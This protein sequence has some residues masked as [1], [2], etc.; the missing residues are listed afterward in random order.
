[1]DALPF[2][3]PALIAKKP[4]ESAYPS[5]LQTIGD[6]IRARRLDLRIFQ[7]D[8]AKRIGVTTDTITN[9][10][11]HRSTPTLRAWPAVLLFLGYDPRPDGR[12]IGE[13]LR[14]RRQALGLS[15]AEA[16]RIIGVDPSTLSKWEFGRRQPVGVHLEKVDRFLSESKLFKPTDKPEIS[17]NR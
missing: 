15:W 8:V 14:L 16:A 7:K 13:K 10:E 4:K 3:H 1:M 12:T 11:K 5:E 6:H 9:W 2:Y 17:I